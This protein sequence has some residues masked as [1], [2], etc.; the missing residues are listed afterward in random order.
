MITKDI[1]LRSHVVEL[2][3]TKPMSSTYNEP[4]WPE[5]ALV[6]DTET[7]LDPKTQSL[8]F[9][10][11]RVCKLKGNEYVC[12]EEGILYADDLR[13]EYLE[14]IKD[15]K[16]KSKSE[17]VGN[18]YDQQLHIYSRSEF[19]EKVFFE[20]IRTRSLIVAFNAPWDISRISIDYRI[21]RNRS[22]TLILS[23][24]I[25]RKTGKVE[26]NPERPCMRVTSKDS[27]AAFFSLTKPFRPKEWP[28]YKV[29]NKTRI[30]CRV[31]DLHTLAWALYNRSYSLKK[32]CE[33][34]KTPNQKLDHDPTGAV[35]LEELEYC[36][37]DVRCTVDALNSLKAEFELHPIQI[38]PDKAVSPA[39][40]GKAYMSTMGIIP[41]M[42]KFN[43]PDHMLGIA[44]QAY[45]GGRAECKIRN[46]PVPVVLTDF[47]SQYPTINSLLGNPEILIAEELIFEDATE[48]I[49]KFVEQIEL[50]D[51]FEQNI[52]KEMKFCARIRPDRDVL[53]ARAEYSQDGITKNIGVNYLTSKKPIWLSGPDIVASKLLSGKTPIIEK[54][55]RMVPRGVQQGLKV[56]SLRGMVEVDPRKDDLFRVMVEQKQVFK[57]SNEALSYFLK[58]CAN[59]TSYGMFFELT[60]QKKSKPVK[61][62]VFSGDH[63]HEQSVTTLEKP[64]E[65][66]FPP[67]AALITGGAHLFLAMLERC[68]ADKGGSY[69]FCDTDS[70][71]IVASKKG[72]RIPCGD[73]SSIHAISW[74]QVDEIADRFASLNCYDKSKVPGSILKVEK[75][76]F[77]KKKQIELFGYGISAK[78]YVLYRYDSRGN[79]VIVDAKAHGLGYLFPPKDTVE[80][81]AESDWLFEAWHWLLEG[82]VATPCSTPEWFQYPAM[83]RMTVSTPAVLGILKRYT[84]P[85]NFVLVPLLF[86]RAQERGGLKLNLVMPFSKRRDEWLN[87]MATD[88]RTGKPYSIC[89]LHPTAR[90]KKVEVK[91]YGN[92]LGEYRNHPEAKFL[93]PDGIPCHSQTSGLLQR[94]EIVAERIRYIGKETSRR[95]EQGDDPSLVDFR[96]TEYAPDKVAAD[97][98]V[99]KRIIEIGI[100]RITN[101][102]KIDRKTVRLIAQGGRVKAKTL[103]I[104][105]EFISPFAM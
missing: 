39:S 64:G 76:N 27:K 43:V 44:S 12:V 93:G 20:A 41:P 54:A 33:E 85:F 51:C 84:R 19:V 71:C 49:R 105:V 3:P 28:L 42:Q 25:S 55:I 78:R 66:Y 56:T 88:T 81:D 6:F 2:E 53:P 89:L 31:L 100:R 103:A 14:I 63:S 101:E 17:V 32:F 87:T 38:H 16:R 69:L 37:Q 67:I 29:G 99:R 46:T 80:D 9:G 35:T 8:L 104:V 61:V 65:W 77:Y 57:E 5:Y 82:A 13:P 10:F 86:Q 36:R 70:L 94:S 22:F 62:R 4:K 30:V 58:I 45:F 92:I 72:D 48:E 18:E 73:G 40:I 34:H 59:S 15:F 98:E 52:W 79:I 96:C 75:V 11:Y 90:T 97:P 91:C 1:F 102:C 83:M 21:A 23:Q 50:D 47:S 26:P 7:T 95:W 68:V 74:K 24:R 60:L